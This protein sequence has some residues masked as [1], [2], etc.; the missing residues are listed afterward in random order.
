MFGLSLSSEHY[1]DVCYCYANYEVAWQLLRHNL[2]VRIERLCVQ[3]P[4]QT[5][6]AHPLPFPFVRFSAYSPSVEVKNL[7][8]MCYRHICML[9]I[10]CSWQC[11]DVALA[12]LLS[13]QIQYDIKKNKKELGMNE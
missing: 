11:K 8:P 5:I 6:N 2:R 13:F 12:K 4:V 7:D 1:I 10:S 3:I 9:K